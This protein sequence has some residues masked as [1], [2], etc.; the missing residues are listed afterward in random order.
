[1]AAPADMPTPSRWD[2]ILA[3]LCVACP[4]CAYARHRQ[5]GLAFQFVKKVESK[6]CPFCAA[7]EKVYGRKAHEPVPPRVQPPAA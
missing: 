5:K 1:M 3:D 4:L 6:A 7:Y 2:R